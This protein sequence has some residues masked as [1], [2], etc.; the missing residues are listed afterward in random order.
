MG[1]S[2]GVRR[3]ARKIASESSMLMLPATGTPRMLALSWR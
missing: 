2:G 3:M 1:W